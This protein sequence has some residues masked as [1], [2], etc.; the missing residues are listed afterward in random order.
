MDKVTQEIKY[1][2]YK[3][4]LETGE[5]ARQAS[6]S[7]I[8]QYRGVTTLVTA[9]AS[10]EPKEDAEFVPLMVDFEERMYAAGKFPGGFFKREGRP[11]D[12]AILNA[13]KIDRSIRPLFPKTLRHEVQ[14]VATPLSVDQLNPPDV[15]AI[16][17]AS[18]A[19]LLSGIPFKEPIASVR[20][21]RM[22]GD[23]ILGPTFPQLQESDIDLLVAGTRDRISMIENQ[24]KEA[25]E[26]AIL[27]C[28]KVAQE[29][30]RAMIPEIEKFALKARETLNL[31]PRVA[32]TE[33]SAP[34]QE[35]V[36]K[37]M[38]ALKPRITA[39][40]PSPTKD[41]LYKGLDNAKKEVAQQILEEFP[42]IPTTEIELI[43]DEVIRKL[44]RDFVFST[45]KRADGRGLKDIREISGRVG[46]L[47]RVHGS[48][49]FTRGQTQVISSVTLGTFADRQKIDTVNIEAEKRFVHHYNFPPYSVGEVRPMRGPGRR[50]I[51]HGA[52]V[53][54]SLEPLIPPESE[55]P[56]SIRVVSEVTESH[57]SSSMAS[58][59]GSS[60]A[61]MDAGVPIPRAVGGVSI[62]LIY[63]NDEKYALITDISGFEDHYGD[64]DFKIA[65]TERGVTAIQLDTKIDGLTLRILEEAL[66]LGREARIHILNQMNRIIDKPRPSLSEFAPT[67]L[68]LQVPVD[69]IGQ[70]I[71]PAGRNVKK[72]QSETGS[73]IDI[74]E[75]GTV[76]ISGYD[77]RGVYKAYETIK[78]MTQEIEPDMVFEGTVVGITPFGAFVELVPGRD[79]LLHISN[80]TDHRIERVEDYL[81]IGD[82]VLVRV[83]EVDPSGKISV[84]REDI[85]YP[86]SRRTP[87]PVSQRQQSRI[88]THTGRGTR[89]HSSRDFVGGRS[90]SKKI[91]HTKP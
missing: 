2:E 37:V 44:Y 72:I 7:C 39:L 21:A 29:H 63:E 40:F 1:G 47:P 31:S 23:I 69:K 6:G 76:Y 51:G 60:M 89:E 87:R 74:D 67:L 68:T 36:E 35:L 81:K 8:V 64:M 14:I 48:A 46:F 62:G 80:V 45:G 19:I 54:K 86:A 53:E 58:V 61:L 88:S 4:V 3:L 13:R 22:H 73:S 91:H 16:I 84:I 70:V 49:T 12:E 5:F 71:G 15:P 85:E 57:A 79:G 65:G 11:S 9:T 78:M 82:K 26:S 17:G 75:N 90:H 24:S 28:L 32:F 20:V 52:L 43:E 59:C 66:Y 27:D 83:K 33:N 10:Q 50:E 56:Y 41:E 77:K 38:N 30:I 25:D 55:F 42:D 18:A 34:N